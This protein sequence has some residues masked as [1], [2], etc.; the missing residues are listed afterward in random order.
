MN[1]MNLLIQIIQ[2]PIAMYSLILTVIWILIQ[3]LSKLS[4]NDIRIFIK[5]KTLLLL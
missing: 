5:E 2:T 1:L 3:L 4:L